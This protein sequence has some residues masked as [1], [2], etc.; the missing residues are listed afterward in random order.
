MSME[1]IAARAGVSKVSLN[2]RWKSKLT[3][4]ADVLRLL[5]EARVPE[6]HG[7]LESDILALIEASIDLLRRQLQRRC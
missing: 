1:A 4:T 5:S 2:R 7:S 6:D 3:A